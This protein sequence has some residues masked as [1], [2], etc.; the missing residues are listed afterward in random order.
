MSFDKVNTLQPLSTVARSVLKN[1]ETA[2]SKLNLTSSISEI[3]IEEIEAQSQECGNKI[4]LAFCLYIAYIK[5]NH[6][7]HL[8]QSNQNDLTGH[9]Y[10]LNKRSDKIFGMLAENAFRFSSIPAGESDCEREIS[11]ARWIFGC[12]QQREKD[13]LTTARIL[14]RCLL[15]KNDDSN[16]NKVKPKD[17]PQKRNY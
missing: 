16:Q 5:S 13:D 12:Y 11:K 3:S 15:H 14:A 6:D 8:F 1:R 7:F 9:I 10:W 17:K 2:R 4:D